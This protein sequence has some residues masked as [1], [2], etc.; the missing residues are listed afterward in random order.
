MTFVHIPPGIPEDHNIG[1]FQVVYFIL[2]RLVG[3]S[4]A[5]LLSIVSGYFIVSS[6][7]KIGPARLIASKFKTLVIPLVAWNLLMLAL[8]TAYGILTGNWQDMPAFSPMGVTNALLAITE[9]PLVIPLWF[10]RD[11]F[12]CCL[13]SPILYVGL[14]QFPAT[15][16][17]LLIG[18]TL[19][20][21]DLYVLQRPQLLLFFGLGM[22]LRIA[23]SGEEAIDRAARLLTFGLV[24]MVA[25]FL[26]FWVERILISEMS[27]VLR[28]TLDTLLRLT[29]AAA[30]W[31]LTELIRKSSCGQGDSC[32]WSPMCSSCSAAT[33]SYSTSAG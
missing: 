32:G 28:L 21:E 18:Y 26:A 29:M 15:T 19:F 11:L 1:F 25:I 7:L 20:S 12:V 14:K 17:V 2:T 5:S 4:S 6:L 9:W 23:K 27:D 30:F 3:L 22:W 31:Q 8:L 24:P 16:I 33:L 10:L 13:F